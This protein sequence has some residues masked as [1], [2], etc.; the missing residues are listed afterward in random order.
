MTEINI[1]YFPPPPPNGHPTV[2]GYVARIAIDVS[3]VP[4]AP[5]DYSEWHAGLL[6]SAPIDAIFVI[7]SEPSENG[8]ALA[9]T[10]HETFDRPGQEYGIDWGVWFIPEPGAA[11]LLVM[12]TALALSRRRTFG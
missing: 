8:T 3:G 9:G 1:A 10:V 4:G 5:Q 7:R 12:G 11:M 6:E 2:S